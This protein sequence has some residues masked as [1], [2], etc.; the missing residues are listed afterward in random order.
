MEFGRRPKI[1]RNGTNHHPKT[2]KRGQEAL[3][4]SSATTLMPQWKIIPTERETKRHGSSN[5]DPLFRLRYEALPKGSALL[6]SREAILRV[7]QKLQ[8]L[9]PEKWDKPGV[10][11]A[12]QV[13]PRPIYK[14]RPMFGPRRGKRGRQRRVSV[15]ICVCCRVLLVRPPP[16]SSA[17]HSST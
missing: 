9:F 1:N 4:S 12:H 7:S 2:H 14:P 16:V 13:H 10:H 6:E 5:R 15:P 3:S 8:S 11:S 17:L